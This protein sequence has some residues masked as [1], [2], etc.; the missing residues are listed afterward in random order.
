M[1]EVE[2]ADRN[3]ASGFKMFYL[4]NMYVHD[5]TGFIILCTLY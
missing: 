2:T 4:L 5:Y 1:Q 3:S